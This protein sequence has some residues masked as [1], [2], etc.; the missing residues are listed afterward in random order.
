MA[1]NQNTQDL[2][3]RVTEAAVKAVAEPDMFDS[4]SVNM[5]QGNVF[6]IF[7]EYL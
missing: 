6:F 7:Y 5:K 4:S 3:K 2:I 1:A